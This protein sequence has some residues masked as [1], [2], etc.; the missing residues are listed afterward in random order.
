VDCFDPGAAP[1][2]AIIQRVSED[3][4][5]IARRALEHFNRGER[6]ALAELSSPDIEI[7]PLRAALEGTVF[8]GE[9]ANADFWRA[10]DETWEEIHFEVEEILESGERVVILGQLRGRAR[11]TDTEVGSPNGW[12][13]TFDGDKVRGLRTYPSVA[14]A[15]RA[16]GL[17]E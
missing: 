17:D 8:R 9:T 1:I 15:R 6:D 11:G 5:E 3:R 12:V 4:V 14:E 16:A 10:I 7:V 2:G 13:L